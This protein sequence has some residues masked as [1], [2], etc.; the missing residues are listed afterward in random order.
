MATVFGPQRMRIEP[1]GVKV[2]PLRHLTEER[3]RLE[4][5]TYDG[6]TV[7]PVGSTLGGEIVGLDLRQPLDPV[8]RD[9]VARALAD[10]K[11]LFFRDQPI[12]QGQHVAFAKSFGELEVHPFLPSNTGFAELVRF[13]KEAMVGGFENAWHHDVTWRERPSMGAVLHG[14]E[15]PRVGGDTLFSDMHAAYDGL[16]EDVKVRIE[17]LQATHD[18]TRGFG[19]GMDPEAKRQM[20]EKYPPVVHPVVHHHPVTG[21]KLLYVNRYFVTGIVGMDRDESNDLIDL[22][23]REAETVEYQVRFHWEQDSIAF[24]DNR[25]VQHYAASDYYPARRVMERASICGNRPA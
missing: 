20:Q 17:G 23:C 14:I 3:L 22:L 18:F 15:V 21:K 12:D 9:E 7:E 10:F 24:W 4:G 11:V 5:C 1:W 19:S 25:A 16:D 2:G 6:F 13:E 8:V